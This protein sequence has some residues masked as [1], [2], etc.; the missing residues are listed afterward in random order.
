MKQSATN[1]KPP[2]KIIF[3]RERP[4]INRYDGVIC[5][6]NGYDLTFWGKAMEEVD[7]LVECIKY[8][9]NL[10]YREASEHFLDKVSNPLGTKSK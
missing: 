3:T 5:V 9:Y 7:T 6:G 2:I 8:A 4:R 1:T 10:G